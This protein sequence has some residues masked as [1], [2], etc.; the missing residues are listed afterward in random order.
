[1][2][3]HNHSAKSPIMPLPHFRPRFLHTLRLIP[4]FAGLAA[5]AA[6]QNAQDPTPPSAFALKPEA[7]KD[8]ACGKITAVQSEI[9]TEPERYVLENLTILQPVHLIV[10]TKKA[11]ENLK[12]QLSKHIWDQVEQEGSTADTGSAVFKFR[13]EGDMKIKVT[14]DDGQSHIYQIICWVGDA[15]KP[16]LKSPFV[17]MAAFKKNAP[18]GSGGFAAS[19]VLWAIVGLLG[20]IVVLLAIIALKKKRA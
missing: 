6:A 7:S 3:T 8:I 15:E 2:A 17:S 18:A 9:G 5:L 4:L 19:P 10:R 1:M 16:S 11:G 12:V 20:A 13:T 14:S